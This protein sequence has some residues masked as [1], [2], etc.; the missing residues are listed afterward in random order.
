MVIRHPFLFLGFVVL[1][2]L[3]FQAACPPPSDAAIVPA[4]AGA[5][6]DVSITPHPD[7]VGLFVMTICYRKNTMVFRTVDE[8]E[9]EP[10][11][12][13]VL[14]RRAS[15]LPR[16]TSCETEFDVK[17]NRKHDGNPASEQYGESARV[18]WEES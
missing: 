7:T 5:Y 8:Y 3:A 14:V 6:W 10:T 1:A 16:G 12:T 17:I 2:A 15:P 4:T 13:R 9:I 11:D 18:K